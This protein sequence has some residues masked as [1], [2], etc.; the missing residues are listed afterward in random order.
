MIS[1]EHFHPMLVHFPIVFFLVLAAFD[2]V[3]L[4]RGASFTGR[5]AVA[6]VSA[7]LAVLA[8]L[9]AAATWYF[10]TVALDVAEAG[11]FHSDVAEVHES[12]GELTALAFVIWG[13]IRALVWWRNRAA[14]RGIEGAAVAVEILGALLIVWTAYYGGQLVYT[15]GVNVAHAAGG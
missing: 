4:I 2:L 3:V 7:G 12:L 6:N 15:L 14:G 11:G 13:A 5:S 1:I 8:G 10:G 9:S